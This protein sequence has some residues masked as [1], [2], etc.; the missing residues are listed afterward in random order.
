MKV[1]GAKRIRYKDP[2][3]KAIHLLFFSRHEPREI[4]KHEQRICTK[5]KGVQTLT[6]SKFESSEFEEVFSNFRTTSEGNTISKVILH[7]KKPIETKRS[8]R[9]SC[10]S[11]L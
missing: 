1:R 7:S 6:Q 11:S 2:E 4:E 10:L 5:F 8:E 3:L 9:V